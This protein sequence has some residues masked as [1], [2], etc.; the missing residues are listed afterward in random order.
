VCT[1]GKRCRVGQARHRWRPEKRSVAQELRLA[2]GR[3]LGYGPI[4]MSLKRNHLLIYASAGLAASGIPTGDVILGE[5]A[6]AVQP[7]HVAVVWTHCPPRYWNSGYDPK[8]N[9]LG[10]RNDKNLP[11]SGVRAQGMVCSAVRRA[12]ARG[13]IRI[14]CCG[15]PPPGSFYAKFNTPGF[16]C[17]GPNPIRCS[18]GR[19]RFVF[20]WSE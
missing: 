9:N 11:I 13:A 12:I 16:S 6:D 8:N 2:L 7:A 14:H 5:P 4:A 15:E 20:Y 19:R 18:A 1:S 3:R 17:R 10:P